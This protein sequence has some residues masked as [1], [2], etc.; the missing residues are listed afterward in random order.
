MSTKSS[1]AIMHKYVFA[2]T[3]TINQSI[4]Q[5]IIIQVTEDPTNQQSS[6]PT[7]FLYP[8]IAASVKS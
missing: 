5:L 8:P 4:D 7:P 3:T 6:F 1:C 2:N